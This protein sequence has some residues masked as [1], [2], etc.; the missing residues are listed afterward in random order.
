MFWWQTKRGIDETRFIDSLPVEGYLGGKKVM[1]LRVEKRKIRTKTDGNR[2][3]KLSYA[4]EQ[5]LENKLWL[6]CDFRDRFVL[7]IRN[8]KVTL[9]GKYQ[10]WRLVLNSFIL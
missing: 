6:F 7:D 5:Q 9:R 2:I 1:I 10:K 4:N 8:S 3:Q